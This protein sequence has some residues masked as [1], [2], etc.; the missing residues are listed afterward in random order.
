MKNWKALS[1]AYGLG[2]PESDLDRITDPLQGLEDAFRKLAASFP[3]D[4]DSALIF[5]ASP[6]PK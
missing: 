1:G 3:P 2:I 6:E 5:E 4:T